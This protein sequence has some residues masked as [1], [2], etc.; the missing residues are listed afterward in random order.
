[1]CNIN[2]MLCTNS[3][4]NTNNYKYIMKKTFLALA[5]VCFSMGALMAQN[6]FKGIVKYKVESTGTVAFQIPAEAATAEVKVDG[7]NLYT[8]SSI[9]M[10]SPFSEDILVQGYTV[11]QCMNF[12]QLLGYLRSNGSEFTYQ[13]DGKLLIKQTQDESSLD[14]L[15]VVDKE[16]G[17][18]YYEYVDGETQQI[19]GYTAKKVIKHIYDAEGVDH[20]QTTW[21]TDEIGPRYNVLFEGIKGMPLSCTIDAGE[22]KAI[23]YTA[24]EVVNGKVKTADFLLPDGYETLSD[25]DLGTLM[26]EIQE[27]LE[28]LQE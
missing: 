2:L 11:S 5:L 28:L 7:N 23:T 12:G 16:A 25:E 4:K 20:P 21:Y 13:G 22:G 19:A 26:Q 9:F 10:S 27:E 14:S 18:Y 3:E 6:S 1:M 24:T 17:H 15:T 8:K